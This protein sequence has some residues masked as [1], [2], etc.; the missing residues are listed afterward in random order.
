M[1]LGHVYLEWQQPTKAAEQ[2][3]AAQT[4][5]LEETTLAS[6]PAEV[7]YLFAPESTRSTWAALSPNAGSTEYQAAG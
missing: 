7:P 5:K 3:L 1:L 4:G 2:Y 6:I